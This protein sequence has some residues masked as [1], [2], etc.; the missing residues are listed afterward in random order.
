MNT[1][2]WFSKCKL[3]HRHF[4]TAWSGI[5]FESLDD[6]PL[7]LILLQNDP[8]NPVPDNVLPRFKE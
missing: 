8:S 2:L 1:S 4:N 7:I 5:Y 3:N 6:I